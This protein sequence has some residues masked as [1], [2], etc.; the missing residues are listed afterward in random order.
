MQQGDVEVLFC[1]LCG[2]S[3]PQGDVEAGRAVRRQGKTVG[4]CCLA[5]LREPSPA[6]PVVAAPPTAS[7]SASEGRGALLP[8]LVA[9]AALATTLFVDRRITEVETTIAARLYQ[10]EEAL[11]SDSEVVAGMALALDSVPRRADTDALAAAAAKA[12]EARAD[13]AKRLD[14]LAAAVAAV[15]KEQQGAMDY[16]PLFE[17]LRQRQLRMLEQIGAARAAAAAAPPADDKAAPPP[18]AES[19]PA[20]MPAAAPGAVSAAFA[21]QAKKLAS[22]DPAVRFEGVDELV[23]G[24]QA[25]AV[26]MLLPMAKDADPFVRRLTVEGLA[27]WKRS[28]VVEALLGALADADEYVRDTAW[29]SLREVTGQKIPFEAAGGKDARARAVARWQDWWEKSKASFGS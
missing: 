2:T 9:V 5:V 10:Q 11:K 25:E 27:A 12:D 23:R 7:R 8:V 19:P 18:P 3:V 20:E 21:A 28:E 29:R 26:P 24:K 22:A 17:D 1:D 15:A 6:A 4:A 13:M 14:E 16:R